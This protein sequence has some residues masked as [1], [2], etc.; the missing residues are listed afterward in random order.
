[1][2]KRSSV[3]GIFLPSKLFGLLTQPPMVEEAIYESRAV[4]L[5]VGSFIGTNSR[6]GRN[7]VS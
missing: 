7:E 6:G 4:E 3:S 2:A 1:M 5:G